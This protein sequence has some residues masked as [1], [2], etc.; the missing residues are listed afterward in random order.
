MPHPA[1]GADA[2]CSRDDPRLYIYDLPPGYQ[3]P[4]G[5]RDGV[6]S[7]LGQAFPNINA[8]LP[9]FPVGCSLLSTG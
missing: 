8:P 3:D 4:G 6:M 1:S 2:S 7:S 9:G 5:H